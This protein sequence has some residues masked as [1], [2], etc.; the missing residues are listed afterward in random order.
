MTRIEEA[1]AQARRIL[2]DYQAAPD[3][4]LSV[5]MRRVWA[6]QVAI[7]EEELEQAGSQ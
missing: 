5:S 4:G 7:L 1:L 2:N 6:Q 3:S